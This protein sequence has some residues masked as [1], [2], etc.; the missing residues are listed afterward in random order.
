M[1]EPDKYKSTLKKVGI[2]LSLVFISL[3]A[4]V[5]LIL[6]FQDGYTERKF[7]KEVATIP[8]IK[9]D[10]RNTFE[11]GTLADIQIPNKGSVTIMYGLFG[12]EYI[13]RVGQFDTVFICP[14]DKSIGIGFGLVKDSKFQK[15]F[16]FEVIN[17]QELVN[18]YDDIVAI[19][20]TFPISP[21]PNYTVTARNRLGKQIVCSIY[22][23]K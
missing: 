17:L 4:I 8:E 1:R 3:I 6:K 7:L 19:L 2:S 11:G 23:N 5:A 21:D 16:P 13:R 20:N 12:L 18:H 10:I 22:F 15:W 14:E 9:G